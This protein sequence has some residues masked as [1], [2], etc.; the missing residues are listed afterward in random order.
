[1][2]LD[3]VGACLTLKQWYMR[4]GLSIVS[5]TSYKEPIHMHVY[6]HIHMIFHVVH[7]TILI[8]Q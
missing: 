3:M 5:N 8:T 6:M 2:F 1:M 4:V 7:N